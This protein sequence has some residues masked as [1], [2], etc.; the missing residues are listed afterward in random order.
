MYDWPEL[1]AAMDALWQG[2][3][4]ELRNVGMSAPAHLTRELPYDAGWTR[5][6]LVLGQTCGLP[7]AT[8][9]ANKVSVVGTFD[10]GL[11]SCP[12]GYYRSALMVPAD[13]HVKTLDDARGKRLVINNLDS[14]SGFHSV[15]SLL[16]ERENALS[17]A[18]RQLAMH[19]RLQSLSQVP[20]NSRTPRQTSPQPERFF[21]SVAVSGAHR[22]SLAWLHDG[23]TDIAA[24]D[25]H[26]L[27]LA[28]RFGPTTD[29]LRTIGYTKAVPGTPLITA[30]HANAMGIGD[31]VERALDRLDIALR[32]ELGI[33]G[34][35]R[36]TSADYLPLADAG[37]QVIAKRE[38]GY[39]GQ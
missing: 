2:I 27:S 31:A 1:Q 38:L 5:P 7:M 14:Q 12:P 9:L 19:T 16:R 28:R 15:M 13:S 6:D 17:P 24:I 32:Q 26:A 25:C 33:I 21:A 22:T 4:D 3:A 10:H 39:C 11:E 36:S 29:G 20:S 8:T 23:R 18:P 35:W 34:L 30:Q 37:V